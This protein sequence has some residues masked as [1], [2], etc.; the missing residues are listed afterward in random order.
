METIW[1]DFNNMG[2]EGVR[3]NCVGT[4]NEL[5]EKSIG[6]IDGL[7]LLVWSEDHDEN[8]NPDNLIVEAIVKYSQIEKCWVAQ[9]D[10]NCLKNESQL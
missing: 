1:V 7:N 10:W 3:L 5:R 9:F 6:L 8:G 4:L 2:I